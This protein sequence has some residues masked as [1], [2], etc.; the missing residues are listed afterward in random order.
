MTV[1]QPLL[2]IIGPTASGKSTLALAVARKCGADIL[3]VDS[4]QVY[5]GMDIG[6]AKPSL[7]ERH[8]IPHHLIDWVRPD[9]SF[10]VARFVEL[11]DRVIADCRQR[12]KPLIACGGTPLYF[13]ALFRGLFDGPAADDS[14]RLRLRTVGD[15]QLHAQL[16]KADPAAAQRIGPA[17]RRRMI[18]ALE[19][20]ELTGQT[21]SSLQQQWESGA[22]PRHEAVW[23][24]LKWD[25]EP[26]NRRIN[27]RVKDMLEAG[28]PQEVSD[29]LFK[30]FALSDTAGVAAGYPELADY[31][32]GKL[33]LHEAA[34]QIK[35]ATRQLAR[36][37]MK[38]FK[39]FADVHWL[40][41]AAP[42]EENVAAV[43][44]LWKSPPRTKPSPSSSSAK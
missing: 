10:S 5:Q 4:M 9:E 43:L 36:R 7:A 42:L 41:G 8:E 35:I 12:G 39:R 30:Y 11:A 18:R 3:S 19:V 15:E 20:F 29:L 28:W 34:E 13:Q 21:I 37:Q 23:V 32:R 16:Y 24:G 31:W 14:I 38:W 1:A 26:L 17:D 33:D 40:A 25:R 27:A 6:T 2:V 44:E 22:P